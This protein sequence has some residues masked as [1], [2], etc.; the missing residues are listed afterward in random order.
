MPATKVFLTGITGYIGGDIFHVLHDKHPDWTYSVLVRSQ[1]KADKIKA[2]FP[3]VR[4][5]LGDLDN[6][7]ILTEES[8]GANIVIHTADASDHAGAARAI[9]EG[10]LKGHSSENPGYYLHT[11]GTGIL[12]YTDSE[13]DRYGE[14]TDKIYDD[15]ENVDELTHLHDSAF[16]RDVD[17]IVLDAGI[18][19]ADVVKTAIVCPPTIYGAG[20]GPISSRSRQVPELAK[21]TL[22][23]HKAPVVGSG[24]ATWNNVHIH[25]LSEL[26]LLLA[27]AAASSDNKHND[28]AQLWG[29][30][31]YFLAENGEH[32]W[33]ELAREI[34]TVA[35]Q[36]GYIPAPAQ[37]RAMGKDEAWETADFQAL[38]WGLN[39]RAKAKR[40]REVLGWAPKAPALVDEVPDIVDV[41]YQLLQE[42]QKKG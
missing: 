34:A 14:P 39:S 3:D 26:Y 28:H 21:C 18:R 7:A 13:A 24:K 41:E 36:K 15:W 27:E 2:A 42:N 5:V 37:T 30:K 6:S 4:T 22:K 19:H 17:K 25:D 29:A 1:D 11:S 32:V 40:A 10:I 35:V 23:L 16:H 38:S 9:A 20:R 33:G 12:T 8:S 31:G